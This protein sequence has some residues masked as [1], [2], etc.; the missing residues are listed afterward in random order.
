MKREL[1]VYTLR[2]VARRMRKYQRHYEKQE[3]AKITDAAFTAGLARMA[4]KAADE[5][6]GTA[7]A[8]ERG[9]RMAEC[10]QV[11]A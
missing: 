3:P 8:I 2:F 10:R 5:C 1:D 7:G 6:L 9:W 11:K 4:M